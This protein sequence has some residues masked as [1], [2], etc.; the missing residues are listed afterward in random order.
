VHG[1]RLDEGIELLSKPYTREAM[2][3][4]IRHVIRNQHQRFLAR[5]GSSAPS[6]WRAD[7][8][9]VGLPS[10][11]LRVLLVEDDSFIR[12]STGEMLTGLGH[13]VTEAANGRAALELLKNGGFDVIVTD[14][15]LPDM[16]GEEIATRT[17]ERQPTLGVVFATGYEA[18]AR[19]KRHASWHPAE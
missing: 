12:L 19:T 14:I 4:K 13:S 3:R 9:G 16:S 11:S 1:G 5:S 15:A 8:D 6:G 10:R 18:P 2:A 17:V 7:G